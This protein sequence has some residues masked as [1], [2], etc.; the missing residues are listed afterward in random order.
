MVSLDQSIFVFWVYNVQF[1]K[2]KKIAKVQC[3][4]GVHGTWALQATV[5]FWQQQRGGPIEHR[6]PLPWTNPWLARQVIE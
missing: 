4:D 3:S 6:L 5:G 1:Q 2:T